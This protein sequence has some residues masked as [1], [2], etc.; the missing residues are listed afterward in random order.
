M[1]D[2]L[3]AIIIAIV[4][5]LT[6]FLPVSS[7]GHMILTNKLLGIAHNDELLISFEIIIQL[8][9]ILAMAI[10]YR[11]KIAELLGLSR[12]TR[13]IGKITAHPNISKRINL[14]HIGLGIVPA[15]ALAYLLKDII[16]G[17]GFNAT[18]V[19]IALV[20]GGV[21][22]W[23]AEW[24][25]ERG[26]IKTTAHTLDDISYTQA[27][28]IGLLQCLSLWPGYSRSGSTI[29][30]GMLVGTSYRAAADFSFIMAIPIMAAATGYELLDNYSKIIHSGHIQ[31]FVVGFIVSF[32]VA[33]LVIVLFLKFIQKIKLRHFAIYR[34]V[35]AGLFWFFVLA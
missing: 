16:K 22:M 30:G 3:N 18:P 8:A 20:V 7:S 24:L 9:A 17:D 19:V 2:L 26:N 28:L 4:E 5:G 15:L 34:F 35:L 13:V 1:A 29:A 23:I 27:F 33:W 31:F 25:V 12:T 14:I 32:V 6:E 10:V 11:S 21:Y